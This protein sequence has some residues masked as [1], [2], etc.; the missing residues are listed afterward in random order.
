VDRRL[1]DL[2]LPSSLTYHYISSTAIYLFALLAPL[3]IGVSILRYRLWD[4]DLIINRTLVYVPLTGILAG[5]YAASIALL[6]KVFTTFTGDKSDAAIVMSTL[7]L[8]ALFTPIKNGLQTAVDKRFK[9]MPDPTKKLKEFGQQVESVVEVLDCNLIGSKLL[10][11][12]IEAFG[13]Q[14]GAVYL[15][16]PGHFVLVHKSDAWN[17]QEKL[18]VPLRNDGMQLGL[19]VLGPRRN[20]RDYL[21]QDQETFQKVVDVVAEAVGL[22]GCA[23]PDRPSH[24][25]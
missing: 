5:L 9:E 11:E 12:A 16:Q 7:F 14:G 8:A 1:T 17:G 4:I 15:G 25:S 21:L 3:T 10:D 23:L 22:A 18:V 24:R 19:V 13:A 20:G 6:Q 2:S